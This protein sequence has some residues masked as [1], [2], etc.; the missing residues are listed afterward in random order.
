M[1]RFAVAVSLLLAASLASGQGIPLFSTTAGGPVDTINLSNLN[2]TLTAPIRSK[3]GAV[4]FD[5]HERGNFEMGKSSSW[6]PLTAYSSQIA[7]F[8]DI[9][10]TATSR[11]CSD[12]RTTTLFNNFVVIDETGATH[13]FPSIIQVDSLGCISTSDSGWSTDHSGYFLNVTT[14]PL[15]KTVTFPSGLT[16]SVNNQSLTDPNGNSISNVG[17]AGSIIDTL[18]QSA[19]SLPVFG[20][21]SYTYTDAA[22]TTQNVTEN[23]ASFTEHTVFNCSGVSDINAPG[24][25]IGYP[26]R[27]FKISDYLFIGHQRQRRWK[28]SEP[29]S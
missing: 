12:G 17:G 21:S 4:P 6:S 10:H 9:G 26:P 1:A 14:P 22:G 13:P 11:Q 24:L 7:G 2:I 8:V 19:I 5:I 28:Q 20:S 16:Y 23:R 18:G 25:F 27:F 3:A 29:R 15:T